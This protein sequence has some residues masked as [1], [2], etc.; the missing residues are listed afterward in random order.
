MGLSKI[1]R[2]E[3][4][5]K[6]KTLLLVSLTTVTVGLTPALAQPTAPERPVLEAAL[7]ASPSK[8]LEAA[9]FFRSAYPNLPEE[10]YASLKTEYPNLEHRVV[11]AGLKTWEQHPGELMNLAFEVKAEFGPRMKTLR[12]QVAEELESSYPGFRERLKGVLT[13]NGVGPRYQSFMKQYYPELLQSSR[14]EVEKVYPQA[15]SWYP[16]K[17]L[18]MRAQAEPGTTPVLDYLRGVVGKNPELG[19]KLAA[20]IVQMTRQQAPGLAEDV[21][22][23]FMQNRGQLR[24]ALQAEFPGAREKIVAVIEA[25]DPALPGE[26]AR[27]VRE[28]AKP[29]RDDYRANLDKQLPGVEGHVKGVIKARYPEM[30]DQLLRILKG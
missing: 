10:L 18:A 27:F 23:H 21:T 12:G 17:F 29:I 14:D 26:V 15:K 19:P 9:K 16:G 22:R 1:F 5:M 28:R 6:V 30:Q 7:Q 11:D 20:R 2:Q 3:N 13:Q 4:K 8:R 24:E 25:N